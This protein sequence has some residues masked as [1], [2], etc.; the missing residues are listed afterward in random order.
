[1][2]YRNSSQKQASRYVSLF[3]GM[4]A[5]GSLVSS[6]LSGYLLTI[7]TKSE[8]YKITSVFPLILF[9]VAC[10]YTEFNSNIVKASIFQTF[11]DFWAFFKDPLIYKYTYTTLDLLSFSSAST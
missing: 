10:F 9:I 3:F 7:F 1:M 2:P 8:V 6:Y 5:V 11:G 4:R